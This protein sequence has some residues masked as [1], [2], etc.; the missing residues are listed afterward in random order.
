VEN[1]F[2]GSV[3]VRRDGQDPVY[4]AEG[5]LRRAVARTTFELR[6]KQVLALEE[7]A[8]ASLAVKGRL[9]HWTLA[10]DEQGRWT[11]TRPDAGLAEASEL[12]QLLAATSQER[13][14]AFPADPTSLLPRFARPALEVVATLRD[15]GFVTLQLARPPGDAGGPWTALRTD[16]EGQVVAELL[17]G[18]DHLDLPAR[19]LQARPDGGG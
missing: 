11:F 10:H 16:A 1:T 12:S 3:F 6:D 17:T 14:Q 8:L 7:T 5:A 2:D 19:A 18:A 9:A 15:G 13:A 4:A